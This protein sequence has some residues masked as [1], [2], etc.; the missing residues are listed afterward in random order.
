MSNNIELSS[1]AQ[2]VRF[3][4]DKRGLTQAQLAD[5]IGADQSVIGN[6]ERRDGKSSKYAG[7]IATALRVNLAWLVSGVG[8]SGFK[9]DS[10]I[11]VRESS[12]EVIGGFDTWD[13]STPLG[14]DEVA[15]P[16][17][18]DVEVSAGSGRS[19]LNPGTSRKLRFSKRTLQNANVQ[20]KDAITM[21]VNGDSMERLIMDGATI[22]VDT[23]KALE[24]IK[25]NRIYALETSGMLRC[26][27][28][29]RLPGD[30]I[31]VYSENKMYDDEIYDMEEFS[32]LYRIIGGVFWWSTLERW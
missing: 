13:D 28:L 9:D 12:L 19:C 16:F 24:P 10:A 5:A 15:L 7:D 11:G 32:A 4:R 30:K 17:Y 26:K 23:S 18:R 21:K 31:K 27:Y 1:L 22:G 25:D 14:S 3:A 8:P 2:R 29:Q 20:I 6:L